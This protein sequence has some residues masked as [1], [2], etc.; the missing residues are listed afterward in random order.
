MPSK[1]V[2]DRSASY[3]MRFRLFLLRLTCDRDIF[4]ASRSRVPQK[5]ILRETRSRNFPF[6]NPKGEHILELWGER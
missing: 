1:K 5:N 4:L 6:L 3:L 2:Q